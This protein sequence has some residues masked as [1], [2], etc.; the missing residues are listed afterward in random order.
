MYI[1]TK[2]SYNTFLNDIR[3]M[4]ICIFQNTHTYYYIFKC[5]YLGVSSHQRTFFKVS[6]QYLKSDKILKMCK[7]TN[8]C[9][10]KVQTCNTYEN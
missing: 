10:T 3:D 6:L 7:L 4:Y 2:S 9:N 1:K 8:K 5:C